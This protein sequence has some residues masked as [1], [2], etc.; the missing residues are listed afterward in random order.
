MLMVNH[1]FDDCLEDQSRESCGPVQA[2]VPW[3]TTALQ[4]PGSSITAPQRERDP[5]YRETSPSRR[6]GCGVVVQ[7]TVAWIPP[8]ANPL[9]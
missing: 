7:R 9:A 3:V 8:D 2:D 6:R 4:G 5:S 1:T